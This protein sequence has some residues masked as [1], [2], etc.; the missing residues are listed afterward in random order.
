[1]GIADF[2]KNLHWSVRLPGKVLLA[3]V[4]AYMNNHPELFPSY[5]VVIGGAVVLWVVLA[6]LWQAL[7]AVRVHQGKSMLRVDPNAV[8]VILLVAALGAALWQWW[9]ASLKTAQ[10]TAVHPVFEDAYKAFTTKLGSPAQPAQPAALDQTEFNRSALMI[11]HD[12][13]IVL[14][15]RRQLTLYRLNTTG[16]WEP[17]PHSAE[18]SETD[19]KWWDNDWLRQQFATPAD[20]LPP[21]GGI[22]YEWLNDP[23][24]WKGIGWVQWSCGLDGTRVFEQ[25]FVGGLILGPFPARRDLNEAQIIVLFSDGTWAGRRVAGSAPCL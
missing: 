9:V 18:V 12:R 14:W 16:K 17:R 2:F 21:F 15:I 10:P 11:S 25:S 23:P 1:M 6:F 20:R 8:L 24:D 19:K 3:A 22:A 13:A 4:G 7:N 5:A